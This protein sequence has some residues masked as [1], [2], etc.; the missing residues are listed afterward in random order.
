[1]YL[2]FSGKSDLTVD[3]VKLHNELQSGSL[4]PGG[5]EAPETAIEEEVVPALTG[6]SST[7]FLSGLSDCTNVTFSK[8]QRFWESN[9]AAH[10]EVG[11]IKRAWDSV[12]GPD[13]HYLF[14]SA[15]ADCSGLTSAGI[16]G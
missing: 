10:K 13:S 6:K 9:S 5:S 4:R 12:E 14:S 2:R 3:A 16:S 7:T 11:G 8:V 1:M 15:L